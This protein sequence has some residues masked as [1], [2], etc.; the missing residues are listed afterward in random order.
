MS[1]LKKLSA[2]IIVLALL[3]VS[4]VTVMAQPISCNLTGDVGIDGS[5]APDGSEVA[6]YVGNET[7]PRAT[8]STV[9]GE[10]EVSVVGDSGDLGEALSFKVMEA[11]GTTWLDAASVPADP[12]FVDFDLQVVD[13][14]TATG[15]II[16]DCPVDHVALIAPYPDAGRPFLTGSA[17][18]TEVTCGEAEW[19]QVLWLDETVPGGEWLYYMSLYPTG[20]TLTTLNPGY[21]YYVIVSEPCELTIP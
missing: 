15:P 8:T 9:A 20:N 3:A 1:C 11:G 4:A 13:L 16:W 5:P 19:F 7:A 6:V 17:E 10:Y 12:T 21:Y 2:I 14:S 18:L